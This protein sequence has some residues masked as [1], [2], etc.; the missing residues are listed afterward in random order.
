[1]LEVLRFSETPQFFAALQTIAAST[2]DPL[3]KK[4]EEI[5]ASRLAERAATA[6]SG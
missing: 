1:L 5:L 2:D 3:Q 4:A 6:T